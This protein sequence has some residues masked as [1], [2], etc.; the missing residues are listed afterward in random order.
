MGAAL[1]AIPGERASAL[2]C[3]NRTDQV[4]RLFIA[5]PDRYLLRSIDITFDTR[6]W[7]RII[8]TVSSRVL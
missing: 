2:I 4:M 5:G 1:R 6:P 8:N 7:F 3:L